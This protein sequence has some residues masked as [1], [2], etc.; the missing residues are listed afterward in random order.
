[1]GIM[2][3][4]IASIKEIGQRIKDMDMDWKKFQKI[5]NNGKMFNMIMVKKSMFEN[6]S[7]IIN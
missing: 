3:T 6:K 1:M 7:F 2:K 4:N 5:F